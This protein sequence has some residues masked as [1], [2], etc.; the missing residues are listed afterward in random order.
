MSPQALALAVL[1][2]VLV[3]L[4]LWGMSLDRPK[5]PEEAIDVTI[6]R[7]K[8][9]EAPPKPPPPALAPQ[10]YKPRPEA[11]AREGLRP[12]AEITSDRPT[13]V[14]TISEQPK[15]VRPPQ[16]ASAEAKVPPPQPQPQ[17]PPPAPSPPTTAPALPEAALPSLPS[18][19]HTAELA[20]PAKPKPPPP[21]PHPAPPAP[22]KQYY[23]PPDVH[24]A[25]PSPSPFVNPA[26]VVNRARA[27]DN[28]L[29]QVARKLSQYQYFAHVNVDEGTT[30]VRIVI[31]RDGRLLDVSI[32]RSSG[33]PALDKG[34]VDGLRAGSPYAPL[35]ADIPGARATF[36]LPVVSN[37]R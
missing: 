34:V 24:A 17:P 20:P 29:W 37:R 8:P 23:A 10:P 12:P 21:Q 31:A 25:M 2:H 15:E 11:P 26:D 30:V 22:Q 18:Q 5:P 32:A 6:E 35:P 36:N 7:P 3:A 1:L 9:P 19:A 28:Y 13:Q 27:S 16:P 33:F 14:P 4:A